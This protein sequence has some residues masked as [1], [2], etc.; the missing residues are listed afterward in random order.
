MTNIIFFGSSSHSV[1]VLQK[2]LTISD[3]S[4]SAVVTKIDKPVGR[5]QEI[6]SNPVATFAKQNNLNLLQIEEFDENCKFEYSEQMLLS[7]L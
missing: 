1:T 6:I 2:L 4:V 3:F 7:S 5:K